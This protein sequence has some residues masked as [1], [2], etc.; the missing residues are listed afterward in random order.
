MLTKFLEGYWEIKRTGH[1]IRRAQLSSLIVTGQMSREEAL[2]ILKKP[3]L[4]EEEGKELFS[5]VA[6]RLEITEDELQDF[7]ELPECT[8]K[9]KSQADLYK[10]GIRLYEK[11]GLERR[12]RK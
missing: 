9:F 3:P 11:L 7:L 12:I 1:D 6:R 5:E 2:K 10:L 8:E 4:T